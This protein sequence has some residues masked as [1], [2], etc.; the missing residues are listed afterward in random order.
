MQSKLLVTASIISNAY[1]DDKTAALISR[2][3][4]L[5]NKENN[6]GND[7][8]FYNPMYRSLSYL[9][10]FE[11]ASVDSTAIRDIVNAGSDIFYFV[12]KNGKIY[13]KKGIDSP[14]QFIY[15][16]NTR[17]TSIAV[18]PDKKYMAVSGSFD[19]VKIFNLLKE[20]DDP[21]SLPT[22]GV[23]GSGKAVCFTTDN[24]LILRLD[25]AII[26]WEVSSWKKISWN[27]KLQIE[28]NNRKMNPATNRTFS[29][30]DETFRTE[31]NTGKFS[32]VA[33]FRNKIAIGA[34]SAIIVIEKDS[35]LK[36]KSNDIGSPTSIEF[37]P[38]GKYLFIGNT[39]GTLCRMSLTDFSTEINQ[40]QTARITDIV[41]SRDGN[42]MASSSYDRT[43]GV[44]NLSKN[45]SSSS[46]LLFPSPYDIETNIYCVAFNDNSQYVL[47]GY[48]NGKILKWPVNPDIL[49][50][51]ICRNVNSGLNTVVIKKVMT[52]DFDIKKFEKHNCDLKKNK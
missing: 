31:N 40:F 41:F 51:L 25:S 13:K 20:Q 33:V 38:S 52:Q 27:Q 49:A 23:I 17:L 32:C 35:V 44:W 30:D 8:D 7:M 24:R 36:I 34:D 39:L 47:P 28:V 45:W 18:S 37:D 46:P 11:V 50:D 14:E 3:A 6:G 1:A 43:V 5:I 10:K 48:W 16:V 2:T 12:C 9:M 19:S 21:V 29:E 4:Y 26:G 42:Y 22:G 15:D